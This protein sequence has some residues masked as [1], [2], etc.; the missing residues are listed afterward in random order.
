MPG[1]SDRRLWIVLEG[2]P[3]GFPATDF[4]E[5]ARMLKVVDVEELA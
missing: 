3:H 5:V 1:E 4:T 2:I